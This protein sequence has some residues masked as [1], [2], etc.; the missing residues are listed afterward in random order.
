[1]QAEATKQANNNSIVLIH[2]QADSRRK[3][4]K[5]VTRLGS[6]PNVNGGVAGA[7]QI[8]IEKALYG[9]LKWTS[10]PQVIKRHMQM[11]P[12]WELFCL[13]NPLLYPTFYTPGLGLGLI[14]DNKKK[15]GGK[16]VHLLTLSLD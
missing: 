12:R 5:R 7:P 1:M 2:P 9:N 8:D 4:E 3:R 10:T 13:S 11:W 16:C 14:D 15:I 6:G